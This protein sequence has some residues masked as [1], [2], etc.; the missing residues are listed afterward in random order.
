MIIRIALFSVA[1]LAAS[2]ATNAQTEI[3][4][5]LDTKMMGNFDCNLGGNGVDPAPVNKVY[6]HSGACS[7]N[8]GSIPSET[9]EEYCGSQIVPFD[10]D[11]WQHV[12]GNWGEFPADDGVGE[13]T[14][15]GNGVYEI[16]YTPENYYSNASVVSTEANSS[17]S[18]VSSPLD[19]S[20]AIHVIG[21]VFRNED[22][23]QSGRDEDFCNDI[24]IINYGK[25]NMSIV[26]SDFLVQDFVELITETGIEDYASVYDFNIGPNP[27]SGITSFNI[28]MKNPMKDVTISLSNMLAQQVYS[29]T[30][31]LAKGLNRIEWDA[32][33]LPVGV[34]MTTIGSSNGL[35]AQERIL[36]K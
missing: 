29:T 16:T 35:I 31:N 13:M 10:A 33:K 6:M 36:V 21:M 32:S 5:R 22:G 19:P 27:T 8:R 18:T 14:A 9:A 26:N 2:L 7:E 12:V 34:Y 15:M 24:F 17:G 3:T 23:T 25:P 4:V 11:V 1:V 28:G 30:L 20:N